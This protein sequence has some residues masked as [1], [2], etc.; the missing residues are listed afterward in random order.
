MKKISFIL[1]LILLSSANAKSQDSL[2]VFPSR[3]GVDVTINSIV[4][5]EIDVYEFKYVISVT[6]NS[7]Q[8]LEEI[9]IEIHSGISEIISPENW[10]G[11]ISRGENSTILWGSDDK[12]FD[13]VIGQSLNGFSTKSQGLP[14][15]VKYYAR[16]NAEIPEFPFGEAPPQELV[17]GN[18]IFENSVQGKTIGPKSPPDPFDHLEFL[19]SLRNYIPQAEELEWIDGEDFTGDLSGLLDDA[20]SRLAAGDSAGAAAPLASFTSLLEQV[21]QGEGPPG[22]ALTS[23]GYGLL[24]FNAQYLLGRLP[25]PPG[26][27]PIP[28]LPAALSIAS[29]SATGAFAGDAFAISGISHGADGQPSGNGMDVHGVAATTAAARQGLLSGLQSFQQDNITGSGTPPDIV[30]QPLSFNPDSLIGQVLS[31]A[32]QSLPVNASG[33]FGSAGQP[34]VVHAPQG[35]M[36][37]GTIT[38]NGILLVDG[39]FF[40]SGTINWTGLV[41]HRDSPVSGPALSVSTSLNITGAMLMVNQGPWAASIQVSNILNI[42]YSP[43]V[44]LQLRQTLATP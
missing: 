41:I 2:F 23:E 25:A 40:V 27:F 31:A 33:S 15:I 39:P 29:G 43:G 44:L 42:R 28:E 18:D 34:V 30:Q 13:I 4:N 20:R 21:E 14:A 38:G 11:L 26:G 10:L 22:A 6:E 5:K 7:T 24:F 9:F 3:S 1:F 12:M 19:D 32:G 35:L 37:S 17:I 16:G 36:S 8:Q